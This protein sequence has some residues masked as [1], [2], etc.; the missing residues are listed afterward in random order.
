MNFKKTTETQYQFRNGLKVDISQEDL[1]VFQDG[2]IVFS[3]TL[4]ETSDLVDVLVE[5]FEDRRK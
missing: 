4:E 3:K 2:E 5:V 1:T